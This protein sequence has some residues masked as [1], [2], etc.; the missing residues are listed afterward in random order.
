MVA[1]DSADSAISDNED[2]ESDN[3][4]EDFVLMSQSRSAGS[5]SPSGTTD[6]GL[7]FP[8]SLEARVAVLEREIE[9][10]KTPQ[11]SVT[12]LNE[13]IDDIKATITLIR[14][15]VNKCLEQCT[16][17]KKLLDPTK[18]EISMLKEKIRWLEDS[19]DTIKPDDA[20]KRQTRRSAEIKGGSR[21]SF[22]DAVIIG[23]LVGMIFLGSKLNSLM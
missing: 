21:F 15:D 5:H 14:K 16:I 20:T 4:N 2:S 19:R 11:Q 10:L 6:D 3:E 8:S 1:A 7:I 13:E 17:E 22:N 23:F 12:P 18:A 9:S